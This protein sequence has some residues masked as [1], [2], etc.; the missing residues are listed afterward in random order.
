[1]DGLKKLELNLETVRELSEDDLQSV[2]GGRQDTKIPT[3]ITTTQTPACPSG[4]TW[5]TSCE[6]YSGQTCS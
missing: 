2:A 6:T 5:F 1:M 3:I 4:A